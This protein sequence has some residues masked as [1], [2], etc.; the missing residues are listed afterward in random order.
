MPRPLSTTVTLL[1]MWIVTSMVVQAVLA[2]APDVHGGT[3]AHCVET[4]QHLDLV[5]AVTV[6]LGLA[7]ACFFFFV[8]VG[9][10]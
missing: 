6:G 5:R 4:F 8:D 9:H 7:V 10:E 3:L 1:S 2:G